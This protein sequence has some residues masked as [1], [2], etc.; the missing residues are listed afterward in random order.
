MLR[1]A[2]L[3]DS[4]APCAVLSLFTC[5]PGQRC[6]LSVILRVCKLVSMSQNR[7]TEKYQPLATLERNQKAVAREK[8]LHGGEKAAVL[9]ASCIPLA[10]DRVGWGFSPSRK[11]FW[12][13]IGAM[14]PLARS[15][16][17]FLKALEANDFTT[18][19]TL[20]TGESLRLLSVEPTA[21]WKEWIS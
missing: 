3:D 7:E 4:F 11:G 17:S 14:P 8:Y 21:A 1:T 6:Q 9:E 13:H 12:T 10:A 2:S 16:G 20:R 5:K 15:P 18:P 19:P